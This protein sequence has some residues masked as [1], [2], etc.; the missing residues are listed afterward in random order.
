MSHI[1]TDITVDHINR[2]ILDNHRANL[3]LVDKTTQSINRS[4]N[5]NNKS[6]VTGVCYYRKPGC[7]VAQWN[8]AEGNQWTKSYS[9]NKYGHAHAMAM[10]I[11]HRAQM[12]LLL[13]HYRDALQ[14]DAEAQ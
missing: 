8:D 6:G 4:I 2:N 14:L 13:P 1:P 10:A 9:T 12:I 3:R 5:S 7:W 11:E